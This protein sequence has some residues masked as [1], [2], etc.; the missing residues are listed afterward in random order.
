MRARG[1]KLCKLVM[2]L[3]GTGLKLRT[4]KFHVFLENVVL[5]LW[6]TIPASSLSS[7]LQLTPDSKLKPCSSVHET[8]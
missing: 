7:L 1:R 5:L 8:G 4:P 6:A 2:Q 3:V